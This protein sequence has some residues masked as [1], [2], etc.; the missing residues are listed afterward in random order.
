ME[1]PGLHSNWQL[2]WGGRNKA[3]E[4]RSLGKMRE[5]FSNPFSNGH[6]SLALNGMFCNIN[7]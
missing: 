2:G 6:Y 5:C 1:K 3:K 4:K 7:H